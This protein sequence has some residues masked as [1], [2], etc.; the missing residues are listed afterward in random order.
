MQQL[1]TNS[2][3]TSIAIYNYNAYQVVKLGLAQALGITDIATIGMII[4]CDWIYENCPYRHK[5]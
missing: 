4:I 5:K 3:H 1:I 2:K